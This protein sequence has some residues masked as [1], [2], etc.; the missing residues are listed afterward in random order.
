MYQEELK[1]CCNS[2]WTAKRKWFELLMNNIQNNSQNK[3]KS[4]IELI[5]NNY[6]G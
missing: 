5:Q 2:L 1:S 6:V 3:S 4:K